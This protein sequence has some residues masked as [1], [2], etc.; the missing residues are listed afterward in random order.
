MGNPGP[1]AHFRRSKCCRIQEIAGWRRGVGTRATSPDGAGSYR[2][3]IVG[4]DRRAEPAPTA[5]GDAGL[6]RARHRRAETRDGHERDIAG[7]SRLLQGSDCGIGS[8]GGAGSYRVRIVGSDRRAEPAPTGFGIVMRDRRAEPAPTAVGDAG[9]ARARHRRAE[10]RDGHERD[11]A[12][13][14]RLLQQLR[15]NHGF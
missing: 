6:A 11:I 14:S 15:E 2:V 7:Q 4:W 8:P 10:T 12:G 1:P 13:Q 3:R 9:L 5:V